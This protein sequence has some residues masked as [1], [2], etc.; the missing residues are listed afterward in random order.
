MAL[1]VDIASW[2]C[3]VAGALLCFAGGV[4]MIRFPD[5]YARSHAAG[6]IDTGGALFILL[7]LALQAG[8]ALVTVKLGLIGL[9][10]FFTSPTATHALVKGALAGGLNPLCHQLTADETAALADEASP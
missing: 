1:A 7:G 10:L 8:F 4:G 9:L 6:V 5:V 3:L 2:A